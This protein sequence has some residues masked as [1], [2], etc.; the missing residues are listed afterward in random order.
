FSGR[1]GVFKGMSGDIDLGIPTGTSVDLDVNLLS[2]RLNLPEE[3][4]ERHD[5]V[6][7]MTIG[8]KLVSGDLTIS[9]V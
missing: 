8:A 3:A 7:H 6:R 1:S 4:T 9:R 2:G 5:P